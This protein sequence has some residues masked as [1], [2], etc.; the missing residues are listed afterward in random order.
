MLQKSIRVA[1]QLGRAISSW[2]E[3]DRQPSDL[4]DWSFSLVH[5]M[6]KGDWIRAPCPGMPESPKLPLTKLL[7]LSSPGS[8]MLSASLSPLPLRSPADGL[9]LSGFCFCHFFAR[10]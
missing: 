10:G 1:S 3:C 4:D 8:N 6:Y 7:G 2:L 9:N 5:P